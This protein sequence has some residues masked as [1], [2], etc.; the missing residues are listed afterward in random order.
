M[1]TIIQ[2]EAIDDY[3]LRPRFDD[4]TVGEVDL[5]DLAGRGVIAAWNHRFVPM[6]ANGCRAPV[7]RE[8]R[9]AS[10]VDVPNSDGYSSI[11]IPFRRREIL[12]GKS[13]TGLTR[14]GIDIPCTAMP[15]GAA[16]RCRAFS[17]VHR[18]PKRVDFESGDRLRSTG[19]GKRPANNTFGAAHAKSS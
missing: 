3:R 16:M 8:P 18:D 17:P 19:A 10:G 2:V 4:G 12:P 13:P 1:H 5:S 9:F 6:A 15:D 11:T 14:V 7:R